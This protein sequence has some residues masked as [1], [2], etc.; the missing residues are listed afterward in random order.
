[1]EDRR[2]KH[3]H[4]K[5]QLITQERRC[6]PQTKEKKKIL[7]PAFALEIEN[8]AGSTDTYISAAS[9]CSVSSLLRLFCH[10]DSSWM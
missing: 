6:D 5:K 2:D 4:R 10:K 7:C 1:M 9:V 3:S 8:L